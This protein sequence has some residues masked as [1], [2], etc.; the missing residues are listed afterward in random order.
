[1]WFGQRSAPVAAGMTTADAI[2]QIVER[3]QAVI[4]FKPDGTILSANDMFL[5]ALGYTADEVVGQ[6]HSMFVQRKFR[7]TRAYEEFWEMLRAGEFFTGEFPRITKEDEV[8]W[9]AATYAPVFD[10]SGEVV[11]ITKIAT[12]IT[13]Q[14]E[15]VRAISKG[16]DALSQGDLTYRVSLDAEDRMREVA[17]SFNSA[18]DNVARLIT[19]VQ[20]ASTAIDSISAQIAANSDDLS[21]RTETQAA[22]LEQTAAA[23]EELNV[24]ARS[25]ADYAAEVGQE[26][27]ETKTAAEGSGKVVGDVTAAMKRIEDSSESISQIISVIDDIAFQTNLLA[28][29]AGV[30]AARAGEAGRGFAVVAS[31]VRSLA[32]RS[33][34]SAQ[35][36]KALISESGDHVRFGAELVG[37]ASG[38]LGSIFQGVDRISE[39]IREVVNGLH[40]QTMTLS[41]INTA[42]SQLDTVTQQ[43]A[44][45]VNDTATATRELSRN[46]SA[47]SS[48]VSVFRVDGAAMEMPDAKVAWG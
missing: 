22:T 15:A 38:E 44:A 42:I 26:A 43:N 35:E 23:V 21:Q 16:L 8:I 12:E 28:L 13:S 29:N 17:D 19:Q 25:A 45:M 27:Q 48:G 30:E 10:Q 41:E 24:N 14:R 33:A 40:E 34:E 4:H 32:Q 6:H 46:S 9:I 20:S 37:R 2:V 18:V 47:L 31:E 5:T 36:I 11:Q 7:K 3:T 1:M 39:R